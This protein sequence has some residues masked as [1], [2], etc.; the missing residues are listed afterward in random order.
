MPFREWTIPM[1][2]LYQFVLQT[3]KQPADRIDKDI[4]RYPDYVGTQEA[5]APSRMPEKRSKNDQR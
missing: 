4:Q 1:N 2:H 3:R 5:A